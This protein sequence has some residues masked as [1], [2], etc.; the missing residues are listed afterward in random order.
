MIGVNLMP[1]KILIIDDESRIVDSEEVR[2]GIILDFN[3]NSQVVDTQP[4]ETAPMPSEGDAA[5][6][7]TPND[8][9]SSPYQLTEG[10]VAQP[11]FNAGGGGGRR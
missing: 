10:E 6:V 2:P 7:A 11:G 4:A 9:A 5:I 1:K 8:L 3:E